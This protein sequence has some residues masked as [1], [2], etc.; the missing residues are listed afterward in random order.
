MDAW[1]TVAYTELDGATRRALRR[2]AV[3]R[4]TAG[5]SI[6]AIE[7]STGINRRQLY[8]WLERAQTP[9]LDGR[10]FGFRALIRY[11]RIAEYGRVRDAHVRGERGSRSAA[12]AQ[13]WLR[14]FGQFS[15][16]FKWNVRGNHAADLI[17]GS[18][19][20]Y[21]SSGV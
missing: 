9:H 12:G 17:A 21:A 15:E 6:K 11:M 4:Y 14:S 13:R 5:E 2:P 8:C 10:P 19:A 7:K 1:T 20:K 18:V 3:L 16:I